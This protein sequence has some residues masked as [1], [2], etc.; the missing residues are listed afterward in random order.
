MVVMDPLAAPLSCPCVEGY[1]QR[2]F[3]KLAEYLEQTLGR[4]VRLT[5]SESLRTALAGKAAGR[6]DLIIGKDSVV[7][8]DAKVAEVPITAVASLTG[9]DGGTTQTGLFVVPA[10][11]PAKQVSDLSGYRV[12]FGTPE[13][14]EKYAAAIELLRSSGVAVPDKIETSA[15]CSDGACKT[16]ELGTGV[17]SAAVISSYA[18][19]LLEG[20]GTVKKG[21]LRVIGET[22]P[23]P[24]IT[25]FVA[26]RLPAA[27]RDRVSQTLLAA[28]T[29]PELCAALETLL[30]FVPVG[31]SDEQTVKK[32]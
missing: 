6:A 3:E 2:K 10:G 14:H 5:F 18:R 11:D 9:K 27:E 20:C 4:P 12:F 1:A 26:D 23:V 19:P 16:L 13:C 25:A 22:K 8:A 28:G 32:K 17:R 30:G 15:A 7:R 29:E 24:F 31:D 21:D